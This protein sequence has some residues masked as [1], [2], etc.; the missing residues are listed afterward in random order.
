MTTTEEIA[1]KCF[2][3]IQR[4]QKY[5][6]DVNICYYQALT[7]ARPCILCELHFVTLRI[8][9]WRRRWH[10]TPVLLPGKSHGQRSL[11]GCGPWGCEESDTTER[12]PFHFSLSCIGEGNGNPLQCSCLENP[13]DGGAWWAVVYGV[14]QSRTWLK[15]LSSSSSSISMRLILSSLPFY[16]YWDWAGAHGT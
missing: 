4:T 3:G 15:W 10:P 8:S 5:D 14:T 2:V 11:V 16:S 9:M 6:F 13:R 7:I 12:L 1:E